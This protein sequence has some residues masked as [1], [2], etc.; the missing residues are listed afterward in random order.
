MEIK[1]KKYKYQ[2]VI[3]EEFTFDI[4]EEGIYLFQTGIRRSIKVTPEWTSWN[5]N[6]GKREEIWKLNFVCVYGS[7]EAKIE[8]FSIQ[9]SEL[10]HIYS[11]IKHEH[12]RLLEFI[13][14][15]DEYDVRT[16]EQFDADFDA[17]L[18]KFKE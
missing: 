18:Q 12:Y 13:G 2:K 16:K 8:A 5:E 3:D 9:V 1:V 10:A 14:D 7:M 4:P 6:Q 17:V 15:R 11:T